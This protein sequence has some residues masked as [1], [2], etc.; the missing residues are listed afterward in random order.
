MV[1]RLVDRI[2]DFDADDEAE[3]FGVPIFGGGGFGV[4][5]ESCGRVIAAN[6]DAFAARSSQTFG[7]RFLARSFVKEQMLD[8]VA[9]RAAG[10]AG[11][12]VDADVADLLF[13]AGDVAIDVD[14]A[15]AGEMLEHG[16]GGFCDDGADEALA[17]AGDDQVDVLIELEE[18]RDEGAVGG[19]DELH[20]VGEST[21]G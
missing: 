15:V 17:A 18:M 7:S 2:D 20:G 3:I 6:F 4:G 14:V 9:D 16:D 8:G 21:A 11:F 19:F 5:V 1:D 12:G 13:H 10:I